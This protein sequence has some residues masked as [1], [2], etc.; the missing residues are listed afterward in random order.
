MFLSL[1]FCRSNWKSPVKR[2]ICTLITIQSGWSVDCTGLKNAVT[3]N[4]VW[5]AKGLSSGPLI[6]QLRLAASLIARGWGFSVG[7][8]WKEIIPKVLSKAHLTGFY[9]LCALYDRF[10]VSTNCEPCLNMNPWLRGADLC[11][12]V[13]ICQEKARL[14][15]ETEAPLQ[16]KSYDTLLKHW[17]TLQL[18]FS[19]WVLGNLDPQIVQ[20]SQLNFRSLMIA[21]FRRSSNV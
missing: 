16:C 19:E 3:L 2:I 6:N 8:G 13:Y 9:T 14:S 1:S 21:K 17:S 7:F 11:L 5:A 18:A 12:C 4:G 10:V 20:F 15:S